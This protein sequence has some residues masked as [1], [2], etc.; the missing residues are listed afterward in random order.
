MQIKIII[1]KKIKKKKIIEKINISNKNTKCNIK[2]KKW[3]KEKRK[4]K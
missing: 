3:Q 1:E 2:K 4:K